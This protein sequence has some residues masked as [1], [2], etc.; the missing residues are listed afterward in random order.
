MSAA[1]QLPRAP[2]PVANPDGTPAVPIHVDPDTGVWTTDGLPMLYVPRHSILNNHWLVEEAL[3]PATYARVLYV[4]GHRSA[5]SWAQTESEVYGLRG[6]DVFFH[7]MDRLSQ[8]GY[9]QFTVQD[10]DTRTGAARIRLD[11]S[12]F[13]LG[14]PEEAGDRRLCYMFAG[15]FPG[16]L[17]WAAQDLGLSARLA[18]E[19]VQCAGAGEGDHCL[20]QVSPV[21]VANR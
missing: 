13:V 3:G 4:A 1:P 20:F 19:E 9:G 21:G 11:H 5:Y 8:R 7:Y 10:L 14:A 2:R 6:F 17:E 12:A 15:W 16:S 18:C